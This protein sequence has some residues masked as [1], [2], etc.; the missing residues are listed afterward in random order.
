MLESGESDV[1]LE[2][3]PVN[4]VV[5][6]T[7]GC[8]WELNLPA[9]LI[10]LLG[11]DPALTREQEWIT[12]GTHT[13]LQSLDFVIPKVVYVHLNEVSTTEN[14]VHDKH[15]TMLQIIR[16]GRSRFGGIED[17]KNEHPHFK[18]LR[19]GTIDQ[20]RLTVH[21]GKKRLIDNHGLEVTATL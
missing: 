16:M 5:R 4:G 18:H 7:I 1:L 20:L 17:I 14:I 8:G 6:V 19:A 21:D 12:S 13:G 9:S 11:L 2:A 15:L 10:T 3:N